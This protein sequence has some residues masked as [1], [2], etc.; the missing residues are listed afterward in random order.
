M[1]VAVLIIFAVTL[2][3]QNFAFQAQRPVFEV[4]LV[5]SSAEH[6]SAARISETAAGE[7]VQIQPTNGPAAVAEPVFST[8]GAMRLQNMT[9]RTLILL[10]YKDIPGDD[11]LT[12]GPGWLNSDLFDLVAKAPVNTPNDTQRLM[13]QSALADSF[14]LKMHQEPKATRVPTLLVGKGG[15]KL[16][17]TADPAAISRCVRV[18]GTTPARH[19]S[20]TN[21]TMARLADVLPNIATGY[22]TQKAVDQTGLTDAFD[23][24]LDFM[25]AGRPGT[26]PGSSFSDALDALGLKLEEQKQM[27]RVQV[28]DGAERLPAEK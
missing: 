14:H 13:I 7:I 20:C 6:S 23:F 11:F 21:M 18:A 22:V 28:V 10:A 3:T 4:V 5:R 24:K 15:A 17:K 2:P 19:L 27:V 9:L 26:E 25:V 16:Q 1:R 12:G 8:T